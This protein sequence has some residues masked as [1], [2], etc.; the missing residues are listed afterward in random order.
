MSVH[1]GLQVLSPYW[2]F[3]HIAGHSTTYFFRNFLISVFLTNINGYE[4]KQ[5]KTLIKFYTCGNI[6]IPNSRCAIGV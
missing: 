4:N 6:V 5:V 3:F 2:V 1:F